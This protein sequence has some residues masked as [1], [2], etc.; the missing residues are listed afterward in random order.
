MSKIVYKILPI[1]PHDYAREA[2]YRKGLLRYSKGI[3]TDV[4]NDISPY[5]TRKSIGRL[6]SADSTDYIYDAD[7]ENKLDELL[8]LIAIR[9]LSAEELLLV[10]SRIIGS[11]LVKSVKDKFLSNVLGVIKPQDMFEVNLFR[12]PNRP[13]LKKLTNAWISTNT[14]LIK[15]IPVKMLDDVA[16]VINYGFSNGSS[17]RTIQKQLQVHF[18]ISRNRARL[19]ARDQIAKLASS[20][21]R[22]ESLQL[23]AEDYIWVTS[24]DDR[25]RKSH[26][27]LDGKIC[28]WTDPTIY[29]DSVYD[30]KWKKRSSIGGVEQNVGEDYQCRCSGRVIFPQKVNRSK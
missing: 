17:I 29:K 9:N 5:I 3:A 2:E 12:D 20:V 7:T 28:S 16:Q 24:N 15:S 26:K 11:G 18:K 10:R 14:K 27:V 30:T 13:D 4:R 21:L 6:Y 8:D 23:G 19:I 1:I 25:V 22:H